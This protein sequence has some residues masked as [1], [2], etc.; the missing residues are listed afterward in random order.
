MRLLVTG[1]T[2]LLGQAIMVAARANEIDVSGIARQNADY[3]L[4]I[5]DDT[6]LSEIIRTVAPDVIINT[7]AV[8]NVDECA[9][10][11]IRA[12]QVNTRAV[13]VLGELAAANGARLVQISTDHYYTG[14]MARAHTEADKV[15]ILNE[16]ARTKLA[17]EHLALQWNDALV[18]RTNLVGFRGW[19]GRPS[20]TEWIIEA[21]RAEQRITMFD[22]V[23]TSSI[24][25]GCFACAALDLVGLGA[26]GLL[27]VASSEVFSKRDFI[28]AIAVR[29]GLSLA[30]ATTGSV[31]QLETTRA[32]SLGLDPSK[33]ER[34]LGRSMP[35]LSQVIDNLAQELAERTTRE[36]ATTP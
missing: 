18:L 28:E 25:T 13:Q 21:L 35:G 17:A 20:F 14:D 36:C 10:D 6:A 16:Y 1:S 24:D 22:D 31:R 27:N 12:W 34:Q 19:K 30:S 29:L 5:T 3:T 15:S 32:E 7:A 9:S 4:D 26:N 2:G 8:V 33:A 11:P 23:Y